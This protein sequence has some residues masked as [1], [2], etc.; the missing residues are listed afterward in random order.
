[1]R[2]VRIARALLRPLISLANAALDWTEATHNKLMG[3]RYRLV[4]ADM[5][6]AARVTAKELDEL[7]RR[8]TEGKI[9]G[10][11]EELGMSSEEIIEYLERRGCK[12]MKILDFDDMVNTDYVLGCPR[13]RREV[14]VFSSVKIREWVCVEWSE[15]SEDKLRYEGEPKIVHVDDL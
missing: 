10:F 5:N 3:L 8:L 1:M 14:T 13:L 4:R 2:W 7:I 15:E 11:S 6:L 9:C 12:L